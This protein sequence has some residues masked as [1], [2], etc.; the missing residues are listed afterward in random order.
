MIKLV[1]SDMDNTLVPVGQ[2]SVSYRTMEAIHAVLDAGVRFGPDTGRDYIELLRFFKMDE[3]PLQT[4]I[5][6]NGKRVRV[7]GKY[8]S[9]TCF[10]KGSLDRLGEALKNEDG[11]FLVCYPEKSNFMVPAY[12]IGA[13]EDEL[14]AIERLTHFN[15]GLVE[16][17][18]KMD[19]IAAAIACFGGEKRMERCRQIVSEVTPEL[20]VVCPL[21][22]M[23]DVLP[24]GVTKAT[25]L[26]TVLE[27]TGIKRDE[28]VVFGDSG[29]DL[30]I[31]KQAGYPVAVGNAMPEVKSVAKAV[32]GNS[33]DEGVADALFQIAE[34]SKAGRIPDFLRG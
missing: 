25:A 4:A 3:A 5:M 21:P 24:H 19:Y 29:N 17:L 8:V 1:L 27:A 32:V 10:E 34:A 9:V 31:M 28:V 26:D 13:T 2:R 6:S 23:F 18:P 11:M 20:D 16:K 7:D 12:V 22:G 14:A 30:T 15:G 33:A